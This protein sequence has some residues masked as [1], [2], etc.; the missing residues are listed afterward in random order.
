M[1]RLSTE[2]SPYLLQHAENPVD[3]YPWGDEAFERA[4][5]ED[6]PIFLSIGYATCHWC[7]VM[8]RES[9]EDAAVAEMMNRWFVSIKVDRE[10]RPDVDQVYMNVCQLM[11]AHCGWPL[12]VL[13][14]PDQRPF[15]V[16]T[17]I[18][19]TQR[20]GRAGMTDLLP[21]MARLWSEKREEINKAA[22]TITTSLQ[23]AMAPAVGGGG[24]DADW[25]TIARDQFGD[26]F[27][28][29]H[30]GF[31]TAPKFPSP[32]NLLF[33]LRYGAR[34]GDEPAVNMVAKTLREMRFGGIYDQVGFGFHRYSTDEEWKVPHFE[35]MLYD[36]ALLLM[37]YAETY[38]T[39]RDRLFAVTARE[40]FEYVQRDLCSPD[41]AFYSA[42]DA[43]SEGEEGKF[44]VWSTDEINELLAGGDASF[45]RE[46][47]QM[48]ND[49]NYLDEATRTFTGRNI[50]FLDPERAEL[51]EDRGQDAA[52]FRILRERL[53]VE[54]LNRVRPLL[55]DKILTDWNGLMI[56]ALAR[57]GFILND[58]QMIAA[59][60]RA[61]E[62]LLSKMRTEDGSL[63][64]RM[65]GSNV[66]ISGTLDDYAFLGWGLFELH[67]ATFESE[68]LV[69][70]V[71]LA[72]RMIE[73]LADHEAGGFF[74]TG[75]ENDLIVRPKDFSD[76]AIPAGNSIA[77][78]NL[79]RLYRATGRENFS[80]L[81]DALV[82][83]AAPRVRRYPSAF[84][85][86]L[87]G[88][89]FMES[90]PAEVLIVG[91]RPF[92]VSPF[93][94]ALRVNYLPGVVAHVRMPNDF[95]LAKVAPFTE[96]YPADE[97]SAAYV[98]RD[99]I[100]SAPS[101]SADDMLEK[102]RERP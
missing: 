97:T 70:A 77:F 16:A 37:A 87:M 80:V 3:W 1:N 28:A 95:D 93:I 58:V 32:H 100:C 29:R 64:H 72:E 69:A 56:A 81:A 4:A 52:R 49:G 91:K 34:I 20:F 14:T 73:I 8:E 7:H 47:F 57:A 62:F 12:N 50:L 90:P 75:A 86:L 101:M 25:L 10:E 89:E 5:A 76:G 96:Q 61:A 85:G 13:L 15:F 67:Q 30:G 92:D 60:T 6:L 35:K 51:V 84:A 79:L 24:L 21:H 82:T 11:G 71:D 63:L 43:D 102:I 40:I 22:D 41:G 94:E 55:D 53:R 74:L 38:Q 26:R 36:Q 65:R 9:F 27:D 48:R 44:Y 31:G 78:L 33:L 42:E 98:C 39:T 2:S 17:Y 68:Y 45:V 18:P 83:A 54:R 23:Q 59:A 66:G 46:T 99:Q 19:K 88:V